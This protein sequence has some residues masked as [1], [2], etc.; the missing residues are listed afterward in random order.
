MS[1]H[2]RLI[3]NSVLF[4]VC[5]KMFF[6]TLSLG[7]WSVSSYYITN[8]TILQKYL[9]KGHSQMECDSVHSTIEAAKKKKEIHTSSDF[10]QFIKE[11]RKNSN[12]LYIVKYTDH[13]FSK[14]TKK[15]S[16]GSKRRF[17]CNGF[18]SPSILRRRYSV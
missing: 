11:A 4:P 15:S 18:G 3:V 6:N 13:N 9:V 16:L 1:L 2:Y 12:G 10:V 5:K 7:E 17:L 8:V 14:I